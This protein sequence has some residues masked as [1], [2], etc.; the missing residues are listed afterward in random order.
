MILPREKKKKTYSYVWSK[1]IVL[2]PALLARGCEDQNFKD[3]T[4]NLQTEGSCA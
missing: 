4:S 1:Y 2:I 3:G